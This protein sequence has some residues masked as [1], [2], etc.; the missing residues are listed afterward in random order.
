[1]KIK[2]NGVTINLTESEIKKLSKIILKEQVRPADSSPQ[3]D[4]MN[5]PVKEF[6]KKWSGTITS[7]IDCEYD[8][9]CYHILKAMRNLKKQDCNPIIPQYRKTQ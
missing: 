5:G 6:C 2:K 4:F 1:M 9:P 3:D 8:S 7:N